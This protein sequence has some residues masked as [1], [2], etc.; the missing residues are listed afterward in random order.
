MALNMEKNTQEGFCELIAYKYM[1]SLH[2]TDQMENIK[3][4][5]YTVGQILVLLEADNKYGFNTVMEWIKNG[6]DTTV[7]M[8]NLDR[9]RALR[10]NRTSPAIASTGS[11]LI[12]G[13]AITPTPVPDTLVLKGIS[14]SGARRFA[15]INN[16]TFEAME[17][18]RVR[19][20]QTSMSVT[21]V[22]IG[23]DSVTIQVDGQPE[24]KQLFLRS[25]Q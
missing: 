7:S 12:Y 23:K 6:E 4:N 13:A 20:G 25:S 1:E 2:E 24:K 22:E 10:D 15:L 16:T 18:S 3:K 5:N 11:G 9:I 8:A 17:K 19:V 21:C 14:G